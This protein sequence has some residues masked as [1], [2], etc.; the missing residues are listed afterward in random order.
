MIYINHQ[1]K[2][3]FIHIPKTGGTF[4]RENLEKY[5]GFKF[6]ILKRADHDNFCKVNEFN[7]N[8]N[9]EKFIAN[10][11]HGILKYAK[12]SNY[13]RERTLLRLT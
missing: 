3:I 9:F 4:I 10:R 7:K 2:A 8:N 6:Y 5:Y 13:T 12:T 1:K 11:V